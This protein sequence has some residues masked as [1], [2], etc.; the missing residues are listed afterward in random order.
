M[1]MEILMNQLRIESLKVTM[2]QRRGRSQ[3]RIRMVNDGALSNLMELF[4]I[5][6]SGDTNSFAIY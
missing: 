4:S 6:Y 3:L 2:R 5:G 1:R